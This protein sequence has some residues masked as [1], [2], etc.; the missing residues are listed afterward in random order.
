ME[1]YKIDKKMY[2]QKENITGEIVPDLVHK[3][4]IIKFHIVSPYKVFLHNYIQNS[5]QMQYIVHH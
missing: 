1:H 4:L 5:I 3:E 2:G